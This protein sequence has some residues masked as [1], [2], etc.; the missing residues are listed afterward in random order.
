MAKKPM[1]QYENR[2]AEQEKLE[3]ELK[4]WKY[5]LS[6]RKADAKHLIG[7]VTYKVRK[8]LESDPHQVNTAISRLKNGTET[9]MDYGVEF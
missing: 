3:I 5:Y 2:P 4:R 7:K 9:S 6:N 8:Q 1:I